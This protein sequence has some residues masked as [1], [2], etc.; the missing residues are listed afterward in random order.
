[1]TTRNVIKNRTAFKRIYV[2]A[3]YCSKN[4]YRYESV[5]SMID[6]IILY[7]NNYYDSFQG[8]WLTHKKNSET[9]FVAYLVLQL[10]IDYNWLIWW[11]RYYFVFPRV[12]IKYFTFGLIQHTNIFIN[13]CRKKKFKK[14][15]NLHLTSMVTYWNS[16]K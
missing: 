13:L 3:I 5:K 14:H 15:G 6:I 9:S 1:M 7:M 16:N 12:T 4:V 8:T 11:L 2:T 10:I